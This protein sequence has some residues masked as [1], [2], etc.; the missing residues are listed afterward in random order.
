MS[1][2]QIL[3]VTQRLGVQLVRSRWTIPYLVIFPLFFIGLYWF[4]FSASPI[5]ENQTFLLGIINQ[6]AGFSNSTKER[7]FL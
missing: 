7:A 4:G 3:G 2:T 6:D 5:G 1:L